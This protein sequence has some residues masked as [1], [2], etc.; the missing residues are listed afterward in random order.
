M[1]TIR[2]QLKALILAPANQTRSKRNCYCWSC[3]SSYIHRSKTCSSKKSEHKDEAYYKKRLGGSEKECE[4]R[5]G[6]TMNT[7]KISNP[8]ISLINFIDNPHNLPSNNMLAIVH[9]GANIHPEKNT[10]TKMAPVIM[11]AEMIARLRDGSTMESSQISA[12]HITGLRKQSRQIHIDI[13]INI[14]PLISLGV[15]C[16]YGCTITLDKE[17]M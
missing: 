9:S 7:I 12:L 1:N 13:K 17:E 10:T 8:K 5:L 4:W 3:R 16:D 15:L 2:A 6:A 11:S 14:S